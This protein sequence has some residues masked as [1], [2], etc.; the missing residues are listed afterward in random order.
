MGHLGEG[1]YH[2]LLNV[3]FRLPSACLAQLWTRGRFW[4][5]FLVQT[6]LRFGR[7][8]LPAGVF[9]DGSLVRSSKKWYLASLFNRVIIR[10]NWGVCVFW[11][12]FEKVLGAIQIQGSLNTNPGSIFRAKEWLLWQ[13]AD[14]FSSLARCPCPFLPT[15]SL[16]IPSPTFSSSSGFPVLNLGIQTRSNRLTATDAE[17]VYFS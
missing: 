5:A 1:G 17:E 14:D 6:D 9:E 3:H 10:L 16:W 13:W 8:K 11:K 4:I 12:L 7:P 2:M 15:P